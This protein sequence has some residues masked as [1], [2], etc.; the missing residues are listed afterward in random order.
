MIKIKIEIVIKVS[1]THKSY[2]RL[3]DRYMSIYVLFGCS[4]VVV[5]VVMWGNCVLG[6][7]VRI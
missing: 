4:T 7:F 3:R 5:I 6:S 2:L 1:I